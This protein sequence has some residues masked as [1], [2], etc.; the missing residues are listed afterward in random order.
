MGDYKTPSSW[1]IRHKETGKV[2]CEL[3][4]P[5]NV[6]AINTD[7]YEAVPIHTYLASL[8]RSHHG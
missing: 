2:I 7:K 6:A 3:F 8:N 1:V 5:R 4:N